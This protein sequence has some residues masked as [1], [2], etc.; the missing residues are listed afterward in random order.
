MDAGFTDDMKPKGTQ[1]RQEILI[2]EALPSRLS[3]LHKKT[4][5]ETLVPLV[6]PPDDMKT[7]FKGTAIK[8]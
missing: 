8:G 5:S 3:S 2:S 6:L 7:P 4:N 1:E